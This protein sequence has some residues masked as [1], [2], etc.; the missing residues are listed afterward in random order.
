MRGPGDI[1]N[2]VLFGHN[3][4]LFL[5]SGAH[6]VIETVSGRL[7]IEPAAI[8][9][10]GRN[11]AQRAKWA[12]DRRKTFLHVIV[13]DK[14]SIIPEEWP[15]PNPIVVAESFVA[16][17]RDAANHVYFPLEEL[18]AV[19]SEVLTKTDTHM[20]DYG[21]ILL[22]CRIVEQLT[23]TSQAAELVKLRA[24]CSAVRTAEGDLGTKL[25][26]KLLE[27]QPSYAGDIPGQH[28]TNKQVRRNNGIID[29]R[30]NPTAPYKKRLVLI[31]DSFGRTICRFLQLFFTEVHFFRSPHFHPE[32][33]GFVGADYIVTNCVE[34]YLRATRPDLSRPFF[35]TY[36]HIAG[37]PYTVS[38]EFADALSAV[39]SYPR[40]PYR[41]F[42]RR[43]GLLAADQDLLSPDA[44][45]TVRKG[46]E[47][48]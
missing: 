3:G 19:K 17:A 11:I 27:D 22:A 13:P 40:P 1:E 43:I 34:R 41:A 39:L 35:F 47:R 37:E 45:P 18:R 8:A 48:Q 36:P 10:F 15:F 24:A 44:R 2:D 9:A 7:A 38:A 26:P 14:Q 6:K 4:Y 42:A 25:V 30:F 31:G 46:R 20:N 16:A 12:Q 32:I 28:F 21:S 23:G 29:L 33:A 5:A